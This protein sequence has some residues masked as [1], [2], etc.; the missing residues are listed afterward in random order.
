MTAEQAMAY[1]FPKIWSQLSG[2]D[3]SPAN[4]T[5]NGTGNGAGNGTGNGGG[6][7]DGGGGNTTAPVNYALRNYNTISG[8]Y[9]LTVYPKNL[10]LFLNDTSIGY[11]FFNQNV[12]GR[13]TPLGNF[14]GYDDNIEY[15]W[16][17]APVPSNAS[18]VAITNAVVSHFTSGCPEVAAS[19][20]ELTVM[21][22]VGPENGT[23]VTKLKEIAFWRFD[24][25]GLISAY[26]AWIPNLNDFVEKINNPSVGIYAGGNFVPSEAEQLGTIENICQ[27][28]SIFCTGGNSQYSNITDCIGTLRAKPY[29]TFDETW[30]DNVPCRRVHSLLLPIRPEVCYFRVY[31]T[32]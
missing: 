26:D 31:S 19:S 27:L 24:D 18:S 20:V 13:V 23:F 11:P 7:G 14:S 3:C 4:G 12:T 2:A 1:Y 9:N 6:G 25:S 21:N 8:V 5:G 17:L 22:V 16:G 15:F 29:G 32:W 28:E 30:G 10:P